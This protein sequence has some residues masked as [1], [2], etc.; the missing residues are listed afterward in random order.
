MKHRCDFSPR[1]D[2]LI[3][4]SVNL[5]HLRLCQFPVAVSFAK[6]RP[7]SCLCL[8]VVFQRRTPSQV[9]AAIISAGVVWIVHRYMP[10]RWRWPRKRSQ[11]QPVHSAVAISAVGIHKTYLQIPVMAWRAAK[12]TPGIGCSLSRSANWAASPHASVVAKAISWECS[13]RSVFNCHK[14]TPPPRLA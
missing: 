6:C 12:A 11:N 1:H 9:V 5:Y 4:E 3:D 2:P 10:S 14:W 7:A 13:K 8:A